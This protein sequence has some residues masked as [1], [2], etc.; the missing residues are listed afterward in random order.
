MVGE[1]P[2]ER[3]SQRRFPFQRGTERCG[4]AD[5]EPHPQAKRNQQRARQERQAPAP[6]SEISVGEDEPEEQ[7]QSVRGEEAKRST[8]LG[9]GAEKRLPAPW[10]VLDSEQRGS[11][12]FA[13]ERETLSEAHEAQQHRRDP[14]RHRICRKERDR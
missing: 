4:F 10:R 6:G 7:E 3:H 1:K 14:A 11:T 5:S 13:A 9:S 8:E 12:P 2:A